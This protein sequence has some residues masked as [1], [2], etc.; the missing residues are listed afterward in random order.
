MSTFEIGFFDLAFLAEACI[1]PTPIARASFW[2]SLC[3]IH[4]HR[5][6]KDERA[7]IF[8]W[9]QK[10]PKFSVDN[11]DCYYFYCRYNPDNQFE[12]KVKDKECKAFFYCGE[13][14][15][16]KKVFINKDFIT[17]IQKINP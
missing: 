13:Y 12:V 16:S 14:H 9:I 2:A 15:L 10:N 1:P 6:S 4:H 7:H 11:A 8:D 17:N 5:M 3:D